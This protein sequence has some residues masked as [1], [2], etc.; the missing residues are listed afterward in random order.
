MKKTKKSAVNKLLRTSAKKNTVK[1]SDLCAVRKNPTVSVI[2]TT[3]LSKAFVSGSHHEFS[4]ALAYYN[5]GEICD[6]CNLQ[7]TKCQCEGKREH[8]FDAHGVIQ[9]ICK[10]C[11]TNYCICGYDI[12]NKKGFIDPDKIRSETWSLAKRTLNDEFLYKGDWSFVYLVWK[13]FNMFTNFYKKA[14]S[15]IINTF[16]LFLKVNMVKYGSIQYFPPELVRSL[17]F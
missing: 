13:D 1:Y 17:I 7:Y 15:K 2:Y 3:R 8:E 5:M 12:F 10:Q 4:S 16:I 9:G 11:Y 14:K 6:I